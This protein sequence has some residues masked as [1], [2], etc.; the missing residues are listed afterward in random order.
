SAIAARMG[1]H[2]VT[3]EPNLSGVP[4]PTGLQLRVDGVLTALDPNG[5]DLGSGGRIA[6]TWAPGGL[7]LDFPDHS[8]FFVTPAWWADQSKWYLNFDV[9][10]TRTAAGLAGVFPQESWLPALPDG[11]SMGPMPR[12]LHD[13]YVAL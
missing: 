7:E 4:D 3:Y 13:R 5:I 6:K 11:T 2:R 10:P 8:I 1:T 9:V 12:S